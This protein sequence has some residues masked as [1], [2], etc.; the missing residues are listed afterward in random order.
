ML[1]RFEL[2][3]L[4]NGIFI[5]QLIEQIMEQLM[6]TDGKIKCGSRWVFIHWKT[7][8]M[9]R[10]LRPLKSAFRPLSPWPR[11]SSPWPR[12]SL[13]RPRL[14]LLWPLL[15]R[16]WPCPSPFMSDLGLGLPDFPSLVLVSLL[17]T[18][19]PRLQLSLPRPR[20]SRHW[21]RLSWLWPWLSRL[22]P[23]P[24]LSD[25]GLPGFPWLPNL[26]LV[27]LSHTGTGEEE[28]DG[29]GEELYLFFLLAGL[30]I[31]GAEIK[32][33]ILILIFFCF[34]D[35]LLC[36]VLPEEPFPLAS[37]H[38]ECLASLAVPGFRGP[39]PFITVDLVVLG[40]LPAIMER[41]VLNSEI[42]LISFCLRY[43]SLL[44]SAI[45]PSSSLMSCRSEVTPGPWGI[46]SLVTWTWPGWRGGKSLV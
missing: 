43:K 12:M 46:P 10:E 31:P 36:L 17:P 2:V 22:S 38:P 8:R 28:E 44:S 25:L 24:F 16:L 9:R 13:P 32:S 1:G 7:R 35:F 40:F 21:P 14:S 45:L 23:C 26:V 19:M 6:E 39:E 37:F 29:K 20:L 42:L 5:E 41:E 18:G 34:Q 4:V 27:S 15:T 30:A 33:N 3:N 11:L